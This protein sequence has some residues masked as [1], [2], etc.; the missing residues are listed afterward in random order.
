MIF[1]YYGFEK[2]SKFGF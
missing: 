1:R 2:F